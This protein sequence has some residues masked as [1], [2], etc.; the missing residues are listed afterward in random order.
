MGLAGP[1]PGGEGGAPHWT[2]DLRHPGAVWLAVVGG[3]AAERLGIPEL[4]GSRAG[5]PGRRRPAERLELWAERGGGLTSGA[6]VVPGAPLGVSVLASFDWT[7][8]TND[9]LK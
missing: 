4:P 9:L 5:S 1:L 3:G 7:K 6:N 2:N 8:A